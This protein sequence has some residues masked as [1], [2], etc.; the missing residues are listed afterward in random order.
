MI[1]EYEQWQSLYSFIALKKHEDN[2]LL[3]FLYLFLI[4]KPLFPLELYD[5]N[6][7]CFTVGKPQKETH[8]DPNQKLQS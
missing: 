5:Y 8:A 3:A 1:V 6:L 4:N 7:F 2:C